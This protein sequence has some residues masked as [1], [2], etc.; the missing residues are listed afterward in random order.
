MSCYFYISF[1]KPEQSFSS[2]LMSSSSFFLKSLPSKSLL[3]F[4][5][6]ARKEDEISFDIPSND[7]SQSCCSKCLIHSSSRWVKLF[8]Q[9]LKQLTSSL[10]FSSTSLS[11]SN[12]WVSVWMFFEVSYPS[13]PSGIGTL[14]CD[15]LDALLKERF[16]CSSFI[17]LFTYLSIL[18]SFY[19]K[20]A[21]SFLLF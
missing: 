13:S 5:S 7:C 10:I 17:P 6:R 1:L 2:Y 21:F 4:S 16:L 3:G 18:K 15:W 11:S 9:S 19:L 12:I 8:S 14:D 20:A